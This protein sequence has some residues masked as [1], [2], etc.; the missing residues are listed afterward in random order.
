MR[1][2]V[3]VLPNSPKISDMTKGHFFQLN[4]SQVNGKMG[5]QFG[6]AGFSNV[7]DPWTRLL[8]KGLL[9]HEL[10]GTEVT[11]FVVVNNFQKI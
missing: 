4:L 7:L 11:T 6:S 9:K 10:T 5:W 8:A 2:A 1:S 3:N